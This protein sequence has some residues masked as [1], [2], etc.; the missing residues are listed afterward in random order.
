MVA[1]YDASPGLK[2]DKTHVPATGSA[3]VGFCFLVLKLMFESVLIWL[4][5]YCNRVG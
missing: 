4:S 2:P 5:T 1:R 3:Y